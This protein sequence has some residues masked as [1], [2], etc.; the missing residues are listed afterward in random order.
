MHTD[1]N[2]KVLI[3]SRTFGEPHGVLHSEEVSMFPGGL[4]RYILKNE[5]EGKNILKKLIILIIGHTFKSHFEFS[6]YLK[7]C[8]TTKTTD[9]NI[10]GQSVPRSAPQAHEPRHRAWVA[11]PRHPY[12]W[13]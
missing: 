9:S 11:Q 7:E 13:H 5:G 1:L 2:G 8:F 4:G 6:F 12:C 10:Q 3:I